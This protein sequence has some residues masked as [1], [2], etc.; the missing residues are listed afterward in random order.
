[1]ARQ[2]WILVPA[3]LGVALVLNPIVLYPGGGGVERTY[4]VEQIENETAA[5]VAIIHAEDQKSI[6]DCPGVR[7]CALEEQILKE[8]SVEY[9]GHLQWFEEPWTSYE[10]PG[11][12]PVVRIDSQ[13]YLPEHESGED[14]TVLTLTEITHMDA[15][16]HVAVSTADRPPEVQEAVETGSV[17]VHGERIGAFERG[18]I[19]EHDGE[20]Y[21]PTRFTMRSHWTDGNALIVVRSVLYAIGIGLLTFSGWRFGTLRS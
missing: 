13:P 14:G 2:Y 20:Y 21:R 19:I 3:L 18:E 1:M 16:K 15:A 6:V 7:L 12:Y 5:A 4:H 11:W 10:R 8:G 9:D 17:T